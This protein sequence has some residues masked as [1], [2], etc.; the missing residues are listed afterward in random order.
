MNEDLTL[1]FTLTNGDFNTNDFTANSS[2]TILNGTLSNSVAVSL[3][4]DSDIE[5]NEFLRVNINNLP[6][7]ITIINNNYLIKILDD[8]VTGSDWGTPTMPTYGY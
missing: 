8:D 3:F 7:D 4:D 6:S 2:I 5:G 1:N